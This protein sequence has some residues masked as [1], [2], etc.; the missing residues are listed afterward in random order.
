MIRGSRL[1]ALSAGRHM[2]LAPGHGFYDANPP[3]VAL[4]DWRSQ[5]GS[6]NLRT[7]EDENVGYMSSEIDRIAHLL[8]GSTADVQSCCG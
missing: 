2:F 1:L 6:Y 4:A 3:S 8:I 5:R 7:G